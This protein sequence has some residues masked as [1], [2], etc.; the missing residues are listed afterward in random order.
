MIFL[1]DAFSGKAKTIKH[2]GILLM[3]FLFLLSH[4]IFHCGNSDFM[5]HRPFTLISKL[6]LI[7]KGVIM[8]HFIF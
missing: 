1:A 8:I 4:S 3:R 5:W 6:L 7:F 2:Y